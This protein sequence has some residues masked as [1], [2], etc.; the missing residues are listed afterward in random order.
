MQE[1]LTVDLVKEIAM[2]HY[3]RGGDSIIECWT[4]KEIQ[5]WVDGTGE[6]EGYPGTRERLIQMFDNY[7]SYRSEIQ[8]TAF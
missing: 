2:K 1:K 4:D 7:S 8:A 6:H 5:E 3:N